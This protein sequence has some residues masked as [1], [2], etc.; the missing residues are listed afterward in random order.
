MILQKLT[1]TFGRLDHAVLEPG[2]GLTVI[3]APNEAGKST[4]AAFLRAMLYGINTRE[5]DKTGYIAEKNRYAPWSGAPM[6]GELALRWR[7]RDILVRRFAKRTSPFGGFEA[8]YADSGDPVPEL[9]AD[10][11]GELLVSVGREMY[12]RSAFVGQGSS[13]VTPAAELEKRIASLASTGEEDVSYSETER[14]LKDWANRRRS[15]R[16]NGLIPELDGELRQVEAD[17]DRLA[18]NRNELAQA[19][20]ET[21]RLRTERAALEQEQAIHRQLRQ[22]EL[23][24]RY[25]QA[26]AALERAQEAVRRSQTADPE[27]DGLTAE[28]A[29]SKA[30]EKTAAWQAA[31]EENQRRRAARTAAQR[32]REAAKRTTGLLGLLT[33]VALLAAVIMLVLRWFPAGAALGVAAVALGAAWLAQ[34]G[35]CRSA[36]AAADRAPEL[37]EECD[38]GD[39]LERAA[40]Y[41]EKLARTA[42]AQAEEQAARSLAEALRAQGARRTDDAAPLPA[43]TRSSQETDARLAVVVGELSRLERQIAQAQGTLVAVGDPDA[44]EAKRD[45][46]LEQLAARTEEL[47]ALELARAVLAQ[48]NEALRQRFSPALNQKAGELFRRLTGGSYQSVTLTRAFEA[49]AAAPGELR[50]HSSLL[51]S[52]GTVDQ[53]YL[54]VRLAVCE[55]TWPDGEKAPLVL[56]D[57][58]ANFDDSRMELA[59]ALLKELGQTRQ[60]LLFTCHSREGAWAAANGVPVL[61]LQSGGE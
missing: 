27:F 24:R 30:Q 6:E 57:A 3:Q 51:L 37:L 5:K 1:A 7:G 56:D 17:L 14:R 19:Q 15:N 28:E 22:R 58:L 38:P 4:W 12:E 25:E 43:P 44:L 53:L 29:W 16:A 34:L 52:R 45:E 48:A 26:L 59:L 13:V 9:T 20:A 32:A 33:A 2:P 39:I 23:D 61:C 46:L 10:R 40:A 21:A 54:A 36:R 35:R 47:E 42:Q 11:A 60:I 49:S 55:L 31:R 50:P 18:R 8:V 41:R